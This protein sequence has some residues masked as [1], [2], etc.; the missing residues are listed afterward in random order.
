M[1]CCEDYGY[2]Y[3]GVTEVFKICGNG[4][5]K[6]LP[7]IV[8]WWGSFD[9]FY[10]KLVTS[11]E[12]IRPWLAVNDMTEDI[13]DDSL[14][15]LHFMLIRFD[16][17]EYHQKL[18]NSLMLLPNET[19]LGGKNKLHVVIKRLFD[20][21]YNRDLTHLIS[22]EHQNRYIMDEVINFRIRMEHDVLCVPIITTR[23]GNVRSHIYKFTNPPRDAAK[24]ILRKQKE[25]RKKIDNI[26]LLARWLYTVHMNHATLC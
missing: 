23:D 16:S 21:F 6:R 1:Q 8:G 19:V 24:Y 14:S 13:F 26:L 7:P 22:V 25:R 18:F 12:K 20:E 17:P 9:E 4:Y 11:L 2:N 3:L 5:E 10:E 15:I